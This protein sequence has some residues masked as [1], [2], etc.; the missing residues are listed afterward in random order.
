MK[1]I[2]SSPVGKIHLSGP[3]SKLHLSSL[4]SKTHLCSPGSNWHLPS[5]DRKLQLHC[6]DSNKL[7]GYLINFIIDSSELSVTTNIANL[8]TRS[9]AKS[10][11]SNLGLQDKIQPF[12]MKT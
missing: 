9:T 11:L 6:I 2:P 7:I 5:P 3:H 1:S 12:S 4:T 8:E 10:R